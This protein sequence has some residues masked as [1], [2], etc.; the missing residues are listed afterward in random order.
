MAF[1]L[2]DEA[3][4]VVSSALVKAKLPEY[5][6]DCIMGIEPDTVVLEEHMFNDGVEDMSDNPVVNTIFT[7][8]RNEDVAEVLNKEVE[9]VVANIAMEIIEAYLED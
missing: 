2:I 6:L 5:I 8:L 1:K 7:F 4:N 3:S 9:K